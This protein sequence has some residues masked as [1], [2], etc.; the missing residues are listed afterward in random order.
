MA[1]L[2]HIDQHGVWCASAIPDESRYVAIEHLPG[3]RAPEISARKRIT[4]VRAKNA[5]CEKLYLI[6][7]GVV[8]R[9]NWFALTRPP[10]TLRINGHEIAAHLT[11]LRDRDLISSPG[12][13]CNWVFTT[14]RMPRVTAFKGSEDLYCFRCKRLVES[15]QDIVICPTCLAP[16]HQ[17][18]EKLCWTYAPFC[19]NCNRTTD[20][21]GATYRWTPD[22]L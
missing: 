11:A 22:E 1:N 14:E 4:G 9:E 3:V 16:Y 20:L 10:A 5:V 6:R 17:V 21:G 8:A 7:T 2:W 12:L 19:T 15:G 18:G 13:D